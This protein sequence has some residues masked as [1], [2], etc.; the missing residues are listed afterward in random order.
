[1]KVLIMAAGVGSRI[2]R[3]LQG[4]PKCCVDINGKPLT[5]HTIESLKKEGIT[6][7]AIVTG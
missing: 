1:M 5:P 3:H 4:Q 6:N 2:S 7:I